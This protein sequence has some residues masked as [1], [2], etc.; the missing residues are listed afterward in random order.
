MLKA[1]QDIEYLITVTVLATRKAGSM[2]VALVTCTKK[3]GTTG[4]PGCTM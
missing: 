2:S 1:A 4:F 3:Y